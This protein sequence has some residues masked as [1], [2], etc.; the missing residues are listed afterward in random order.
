MDA[1]FMAGWCSSGSFF[2][3]GCNLPFDHWV[4]SRRSAEC[5]EELFL[6]G[7]IA[8]ISQLVAEEVIRQHYPD[9]KIRFCEVPP[10]WWISAGMQQTRGVD[11]K[12]AKPTAGAL[13]PRIAR[14]R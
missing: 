3:G 11:E 9:A 10:A 13:L 6:C 2:K 5:G 7:R 8:A 1:C 12:P 14:G 4:S